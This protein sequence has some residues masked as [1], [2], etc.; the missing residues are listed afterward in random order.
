MSR[1][2]GRFGGKSN[3]F[4]AVARIEATAD[5][6][7]RLNAEIRDILATARVRALRWSDLDGAKERFAAQGLLEFALREM[8]E[9]TLR[10]EVEV[11]DTRAAQKRAAPEGGNHARQLDAAGSRSAPN[12]DAAPLA[13][14]AGIFAGLVSFSYEKRDEYAAWLRRSGP[15][16]ALYSNEVAEFL[17]SKVSVERFQVLRH[18]LEL[19]EAQRLAVSTEGAGRL[20]T[21][22]GAHSDGPP[23][24]DRGLSS[25]LEPFQILY[26]VD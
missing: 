7:R 21:K 23:N 1:V 10:I 16:C 3:R 5:D 2:R 26:K 9:G 11:W 13:Q 6:A 25:I 17:P 15:Q 19:R 12:R 24:P 14:L 8:R 18:F 22:T 20:A 4:H